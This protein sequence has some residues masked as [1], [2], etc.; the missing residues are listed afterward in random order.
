MR[1]AFLA[2]SAIVPAMLLLWVFYKRDLNPEPRDVLLKTFLRGLLAAVQAALVGAIPF[3]FIKG[4]VANSVLAGGLAAFALAAF[5]E[6]F[7]KYRVLTR[8]SARQA[9]FDEPMDGVV[10]GATASLGFAALENLSY[11]IAGGW[12]VA[13][14]RALTA[15]PGHSCLGAIM[16]YYVGQPRFAPGWS[17]SPRRGL[18]VATLLHGLYDFPLLVFRR[19]RVGFSA[20]TISEVWV[21]LGVVATLLIFLI[22]L[23]WTIRI[24]RRLRREQSTAAATFKESVA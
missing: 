5:P 9:A 11:V 2:V 10:Y 3:L 6:E 24:V 4:T 14:A 13:I 8:Y 12:N 1:I 21:G 23:V 18:W 15:V 17:F 19:S 22:E 16:G 20:G 7:F